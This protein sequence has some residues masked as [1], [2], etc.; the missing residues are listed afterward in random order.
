MWV[1][2]SGEIEFVQ[3]CAP[4]LVVFDLA[5]NNAV[6][7]RYTLPANMFKTNISRFVTPFVDIS[8]PM[9]RS[10]FVYMADPT[11]AGIVVYDVSNAK[12]W[13]IEN[14]YTY[15]DPDFGTHTIAGESFQLLD[16][17]FSISATPRGYTI[18][19]NITYFCLIFQL[20]LF[21]CE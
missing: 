9:C 21:C 19:P 13:R 18:K 4:Q 6:L 7:H 8:D 3:Y 12:S 5:N 1:L 17:A 20:L 14:K 16:G 15:P 11:G 10:A 2:D